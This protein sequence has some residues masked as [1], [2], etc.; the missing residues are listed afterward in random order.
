[1][2]VDPEQIK[3]RS[4]S[5]F[6][7]ANRKTNGVL[8]II[9]Q[10]FNR[11]S[12]V[13]ALEASAAI[14][15]YT[16]LSIFPLLL[17]LVSITGFI[18]TNQ[19][20]SN[21]VLGFL[22]RNLPVEPTM[23][24]NTFEE[25]VLQRT[26][27]GILGLVILAFSASGVFLTLARGINR[28]WKGARALG[29]VRS[30]LIALGMIF[31]LAML[32]IFWVL[33]SSLINVLGELEILNLTQYPLLRDLLW[34]GMP[35]IL[36]WLVT[37]LVFINLYYWLPNTKVFWSEAFWGALVATLAWKFTT[38]VFAW[39]VKSEWATY[40]F[41]YGSLGTSVA[42]LTWIYISALITLF[43]AHLSAAIARVKRLDV[44]STKANP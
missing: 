12:R 41:L 19:D 13:Q 9:Y 25:V 3:S 14:A 38:A 6:L 37:F 24:E 11:F 21:L 8:G 16:I 34:T 10:A 17:V 36:S 2:K 31:S 23:I 42:L 43:G 22:S 18:L 30:R 44:A 1:M 39:Y 20:A 40:D 35:N 7:R 27:G 29:L 33:V 32:M 4:M 5:L 15:F 26:S 28:A